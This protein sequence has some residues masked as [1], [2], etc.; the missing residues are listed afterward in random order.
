MPC[1]P[2]RLLNSALGIKG[3]DHEVRQFT[4]SAGAL[5]S[6]LT[7]RSRDALQSSGTL[8]PYKFVC[9]ETGG[10]HPSSDETFYVSFATEHWIDILKRLDP[11]RPGLDVFAD[12][13]HKNTERRPLCLALQVDD[14]QE[15]TIESDESATSSSEDPED[16]LAEGNQNKRKTSTSPDKEEENERLV[17]HSLW[18]QHSTLHA[19]VRGEAQRRNEK[20]T[21]LLQ[22]SCL[23]VHLGRREHKRVPEHCAGTKEIC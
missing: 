18:F 14:D 20:R 12:G 16:V 21:H 23:Y 5:L 10:I 4:A 9:V 19:W 2:K 22:P 17:N 7:K 6:F 13:T 11:S 8:T 1:P 15:E 3:E